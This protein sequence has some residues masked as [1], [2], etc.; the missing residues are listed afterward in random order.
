MLMTTTIWVPYYVSSTFNLNMVT[1]IIWKS[2]YIKLNEFPGLNSFHFLRAPFP[3]ARR[4]INADTATE[5]QAYNIPILPLQHW[6][7][8]ILWWRSCVP[9]HPPS[10]GHNRFDRHFS[11]GKEIHSQP[12]LGACSRLGN[13]LPTSVTSAHS[14]MQ[15]SPTM[16]QNRLT[17][18]R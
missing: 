18:L 9:P 7:G 3:R 6:P 16:S 13:F 17:Q 1:V 14:A 5:T 11:E 12:A 15:S 2:H 4:H 10:T 8:K